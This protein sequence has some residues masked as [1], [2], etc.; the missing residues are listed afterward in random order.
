[1]TILSLPPSLSIAADIH[2]DDDACP[3]S[4][5][6]TPTDPYCS[7]DDAISAAVSGDRVL[8]H[9]GTYAE[10]IIMKTGVDVEAAE[11]EKPVIRPSIRTLVKFEDAND[12]TLDGFLLDASGSSIRRAIIIIQDGCTN[13]TVSNCELKGADIPAGSSFKAGIRF[14]GQVT[15]TITGNTI[16]NVADAGITTKWGGTVSNSDI[17]IQGNT[18]EGCGTAGIYMAGATGSS[19]RLIIG[20]SGIADGN[21]I[22][23]NG[24]GS[25]DKGSGIR[26]FNID[27]VS[28]E[29]NTIQGNRRAGMLLIDTDSVSPHITGNFI[30][31]NGQAGI[32]I[33][34][35]STLTIGAGNDIYSN[36]LA[37]I[38]FFVFRNSHV[39]GWASSEPVTITGNSIYGNTKAGIAILDSVTGTVTIDH[40]DIYENTRSGIAMFAGCTAVITANHIYN[41]SGAAGIFTGDWS[42]T[43]PPDPDNPPTTVQFFTASGPANLTIR[44]NI[45]YGNRAG[46]RLDHA[47]GVISNNLVYDNARSGIRFS[48]NT[49]SPY[50]PFNAPW[51]ITEI[52]SNT[53]ADNG[54]FV[55]E[56]GENRGGGI[57]Y[58]DISITT[59]PD[60]GLARN[61][62]DRPIWND[63]Q[64]PRVIKNNIAA[65]NMKAGIRDATCSDLR[66]Y[67]LYYSNNTKL[68]FVPAQTG[69]CVQGS[70]PNFTGNPDEIFA[71]PLF[72]DHAGRDYHLQPGSP[73]TGAGDDGNDMGAYGGSDPIS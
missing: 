66:D 23:N 47:S 55:T 48:G 19:N 38:A 45:I 50:Y 43:Y 10:R 11:A 40:N 69:G 62:F 28:I 8:V 72:V 46:M 44:R 9:P 17:T 57:I 1:L 24:V 39:A 4:G 68:T 41:H 7:I 18:I 60:T 31:D 29:N 33:G 42:G 65:W 49:I 5:T 35:A 58:D 37:G 13:V 16:Y 27:Q 20:G 54:S 53:V 6:G 30:H 22:I 32:N 36:G 25:D 63:A 26:L 15:A 34:G 14:V 52:S 64:D 59:D 70:P 2:V 71:N 67:N 73:G 21:T 51:G 12:C 61:F 56:F 3:A